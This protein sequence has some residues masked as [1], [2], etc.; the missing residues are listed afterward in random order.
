MNTPQNDGKNWC[1]PH[2][3]AL[4]R[5]GDYLFPFC[6]GRHP[7]DDKGLPCEDCEYSTIGWCAGEYWDNQNSV[8]LDALGGLL[9]VYA[10]ESHALRQ[11]VRECMDTCRATLQFATDMNGRVVELYHE[12]CG[13][14]KESGK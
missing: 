3:W 5:M 1:E 11:L 9:R 10:S 4:G 6:F 8:Q 13:M 14:D 12:L 2:R 7:Y